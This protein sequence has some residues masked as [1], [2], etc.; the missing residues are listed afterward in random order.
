MTGIGLKPTLVVLVAMSA[1]QPLALN[2]VA[3]AAP[4]L[5]RHFSASYATIQLTLTLFLVAVALTQLVSGPLSDRFGRRPC[6]IAGIALFVVGSLLGAVAPSIEV[7][8]LARVLQGAGSGSV[9][10]LSRAIIRDTATRDQAAS[11][12][13]T[14]TMVMVVAPMVAPW[15]GG[16]IETAFGWRMILW[17]MTVTGSIV[18]LLTLL[19]LPETAANLGQRT[20]LLGI[21][22]AFPELARNRIFV[23]N[24]V[25][26]STSSSAF[27][28]FIA[29][30]PYIVVETMGRGSDVYGTY[31]ILNALG[32]MLGNFA[33]ARLVVRIG[34][35][36]MVHIGLVISSIAMT[37]AVPLALRTDWSPLM[38]F[39]PLALNALG[40]G[41]TIP[42]STAEGLSARPE[43]A[44]SAAGL[45]GAIQ[46]GLSALMTILISWLVTVWPPS[47][48]VLMW[49]L[50]AAGLIAIHLGRRDASPDR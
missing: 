13:A 48:V 36:R 38:L 5:S 29:A 8:L 26:V 18:L 46:L 27:F 35:P 41:M 6:V 12:I 14:V 40:N 2:L 42:G 34:A 28:A 30:A 17:F 33:M 24:V 20:P 10:S 23:L 22:R 7:L 3:P 21:F 45:M 15:L 44:G 47:L 37:I 16:Q 11:Q 43:L 19:R 1:L 49:L 4:N 31:F 32:Y 25:A 50:T 9:F 39:L